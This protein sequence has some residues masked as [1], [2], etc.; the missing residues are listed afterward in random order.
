MIINKNIFEVLCSTGS[1]QEK[2]KYILSAREHIEQIILIE[3]FY[4]S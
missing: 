3:L 4:P 2:S 1:F